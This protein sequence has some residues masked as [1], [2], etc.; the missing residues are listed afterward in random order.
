MTTSPDL[1]VHVSTSGDIDGSAKQYAA[2]KVAVVAS[3]TGQPILGA[4]VKLRVER[5]PSLDRPAVAEATLDVNGRPVRAHVAGTTIEE[6]IDLLEQRLLRRLART[7]AANDDKHRGATSTEGSW[8][9]G[10]VRNNRPAYFDR[11]VE[12]RDVV[13]HKS[14]A[15]APIS[16][17]EAA[18]D[19]D[20]LGHHFYLFTEIESG[21]DGLL[22]HGDDDSYTWYPVDGAAGL[23]SRLATP[24]QRNATGA[25]T[26]A[27][28]EALER[29]D[30]GG[31]PWVLFV[32]R[33]T[34]R[35][36][37]AYRRYD[38]HYGLITPA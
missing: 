26:L 34:G 18:F 7:E 2:D 32:D 20:M 8:R 37:V 14:F 36:E 10:D 31:E 3:H 13:R 19:L 25:P 35:G 5:N 6:A 22:V 12:E 9:H 1:D 15:M 17:D 24:V 29:L 30:T 4:E 11:P 16:L 27:L 33:D 38:G 28:D 23:P 21:S